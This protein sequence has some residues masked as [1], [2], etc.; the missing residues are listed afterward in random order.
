MVVK[1]DLCAFS[2]TRIYP[3]RGT[4]FVRKDGQVSGRRRPSLA[5]TRAEG[6][7]S[8]PVSAALERGWTGPGGSGAPQGLSIRCI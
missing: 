4:R 2:E 8:R 3:G 7:T 6:L 1:T 5:A